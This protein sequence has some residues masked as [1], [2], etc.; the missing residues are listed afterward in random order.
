MSI[1]GGS[2]WT[3]S[4]AAFDFGALEVAGEW[5]DVGRG[6]GSS[7]AEAL[8]CAGSGGGTAAGTVGTAETVGGDTRPSSR[9]SFFD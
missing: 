3:C 8:G 2:G 4:V 5:R 7:G 6:R 9:S 1:G